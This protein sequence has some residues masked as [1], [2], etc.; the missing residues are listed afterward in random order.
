M[1]DV[2]RQVLRASTLTPHG[3]IGRAR[4][5]WRG[6]AWR[7]VAWRGVARLRHRDASQ[8]RRTCTASIDRIDRIDR[9][10]RND[11]IDRIDTVG[12]RSLSDTRCK[13]VRH[14][15]PPLAA[16]TGP[17]RISR[18]K[19][20][21]SPAK[22]TLTQLDFI[23][24]SSSP[25]NPTRGRSIFS[26]PTD[27]ADD[28]PDFDE[29]QPKKKQK[30]TAQAS[31]KRSQQKRAKNAMREHDQST[32]TQCWKLLD[33]ARD[34]DES[35][36]DGDDDEDVDLVAAM[37]HPPSPDHKSSERALRAGPASDTLDQAA[38]LSGKIGDGASDSESQMTSSPPPRL[39]N[40]PALTASSDHG[41][42]TTR[43]TTAGSDQHPQ[44]PRKG[45]PV[46]IPSSQTPS[47]ITLSVHERPQDRGVY[48][49]SPLKDRSTN[50][51]PLKCPAGSSPSSKAPDKSA[52]IQPQNEANLAIE[53]GSMQ[54]LWISRVACTPKKETK[55]LERTATIQDSEEGDMDFNSPGKAVRVTARAT[56]VQESQLESDMIE[57]DATTDD[58]DYDQHDINDLKS[59]D[60]DEMPEHTYYSLMQQST[61]N[62]VDAALD[63]D[64]NRF[65]ITATQLST[66][67][68]AKTQK[69]QSHSKGDGIVEDFKEPDED[70]TSE[71]AAATGA[72]LKKLEI[73]KVNIVVRKHREP[74]PELGESR[75]RSIKVEKNVHED[76]EVVPSSQPQE[77]KQL[78]PE[79]KPTPSR[80]THDRLGDWTEAANTNAGLTQ[81]A[82][83]SGDI[84]PVKIMAPPAGRGQTQSHPSQVSTVVPSQQSGPN[85]VDSLPHMPPRT[86]VPP[87]TETIPSSPI[88]LPPWADDDNGVRMNTETQLT[89]FSLPR[90]PSL[91]EKSNPFICSTLHITTLSRP[92]QRSELDGYGYP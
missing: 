11:R 50:V 37:L 60:N 9:N 34:S 88:P 83:G 38:L 87:P 73:E 40:H 36:G 53:K 3:K 79:T 35:D 28:D 16:R 48:Q 26:I 72:G 84:A 24:T 91:I 90:P 56:I 92:I 76:A 25:Y 23:A 7:G 33:Y 17:D 49:R 57:L 54:P 75:P 52:P 29:P 10:D 31:G 12:L 80:L 86:T 74:S 2:V 64:A 59:E 78:F 22:S 65:G 63:R 68:Q 32:M 81:A 27:S 44:T 42:D 4:L 66:Q 13:H 61:F 55:H 58:E 41:S 89:D 71:K 43:P 67:V 18:Q 46:V 6:V 30:T 70:E 5:A 20:L 51:S 62:P 77:K 47:S 21:C 85:S 19:T 69:V 15:P 45:L 8:R 82:S 14:C 39:Y 1:V